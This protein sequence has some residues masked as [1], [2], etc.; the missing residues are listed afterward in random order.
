MLSKPLDRLS[1]N[2]TLPIRAAKDNARTSSII[3]RFPLSWKHVIAK[4]TIPNLKMGAIAHHF[5]SPDFFAWLII[6][7]N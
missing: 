1:D 6:L 4:L 7:W 2:I 5:A 3:T